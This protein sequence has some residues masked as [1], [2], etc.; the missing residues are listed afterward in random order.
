MI[1]RKERENERTS[2][3]REG[4]GRTV[5]WEPWA[6]SGLLNFTLQRIHNCFQFEMGVTQITVPLPPRSNPRVPPPFKLHSGPSHYTLWRAKAM[7]SSPV[8]FSNPVHSF[9]FFCAIYHNL[10]IKRLF[11]VFLQCHS[12]S[13]LCFESFGVCIGLLVFFIEVCCQALK[14]W[15]Q[16]WEVQRAAVVQELMQGFTR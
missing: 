7:T 3:Q 11:S 8:A 10:V 16:A 13:L 15:W 6:E 1:F 4:G 14:M 9:L 5:S 12:L 2:G